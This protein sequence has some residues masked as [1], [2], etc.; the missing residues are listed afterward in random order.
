MVLLGAASRRIDSRRLIAPVFV[1]AGLLGAA[2]S[3]EQPVSGPISLMGEWTT[4]DP[5][6]PLRVGRRN[7]QKFCLQL[8]GTLSDVDFE[9]DRV[10]VNGRWHVLGGEAVDDAGTSYALRTAEQ[11]GNAFCLYRA[12]LGP[13]PDFPADRTLT[14]LRLR[15]EPPLRV[16][17]IRWHSYDTH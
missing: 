13:G 1:L 4:V 2:C 16:E 7:E 6:E 9:N 14:R 5:P 11:G 8:V 17:A 12:E 10:L 15:S 3:I